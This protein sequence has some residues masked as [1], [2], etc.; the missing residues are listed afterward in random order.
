[1]A[2]D[3]ELLRREV[4]AAAV[5]GRAEHLGGFIPL[6]ELA[7]FRVP[8]V[9]RLRLI[10][11]GGG[12]IW[13]PRDFVGTLSIVTSPDG[14]Y[15][16]REVEGGLYQYSYQKGPEGGKNLK[17]H[18]AMVRGLPLIRFHKAR[19]G[20]Y[21]PI[22]PVYVID[23]NPIA[24]EF[25]LTLDEILRVV[26]S[27]TMSPI[28]RA[29]AE[30]VVRQ[31]VHQPAFRARVLLAYR[32]QCAVCTLKHPDLL[33]AAHIT[34]DREDAGMPEVSNGLSLCKIHHAAFDRLLVGISPDYVV[35]V[36]DE[37][38]HEVNGPMLRYGLQEMHQHPLTVPI[39]RRERPDRDRLAARFERFLAS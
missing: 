16:D 31:R 23:D 37:L 14:P 22:Y 39:A 5:L 24:R 9:A 4:I 15:A 34:E 21:V 28:E 18:A 12:G 13:N 19:P 30:R 11:P 3:D 35:H 33:D 25:T 8:G 17:L 1:M 38:L 29:Y 10:D 2:A 32:S 6:S 26:P 7:S 27:G 20:Y 36:N